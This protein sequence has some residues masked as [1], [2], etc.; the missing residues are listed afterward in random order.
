MGLKMEL[1]DKWQSTFREELNTLFNIKNV[2]KSMQ[3][4]NLR[5]SF[6]LEQDWEE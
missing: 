5:H 6:T 2:Q 3:K 4:Q 1:L